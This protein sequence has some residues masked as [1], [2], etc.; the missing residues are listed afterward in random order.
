MA[1]RNGKRYLRGYTRHGCVLC[2]V[3]TPPGTSIK[4][5]VG[6]GGANQRDDVL[7]VQK[8]LNGVP[9]T[10]AAPPLKLAEDGYIGPRT[11]Q[12]II[13][14]QKVRLGWSDGRVDP[15]G[16]AGGELIAP[17]G[18]TALL[19]QRLSRQDEEE[20]DEQLDQAMHGYLHGVTRL[21]DPG[22]GR[23]VRPARAP[24]RRDACA[25]GGNRRD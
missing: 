24:A 12:A 5:S 19:G 8:L 9:I 2:E 16:L 14:Y 18:K 1:D 7:T 11:T 17:E 6:M 10:A 20:N 4:R 3:P 13:R 22:S 21:P 15:G 23:Q 25:K